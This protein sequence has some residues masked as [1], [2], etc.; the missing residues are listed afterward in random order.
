MR[1]TE[2][3]A[4]PHQGIRVPRPMWEA[5]GRV[6]AKRGA[7]SRNDRIRDM[8]GG[9][10]RRYGDEQDKADLAAALRELKAR[11]SRKGTRS[12][13]QPADN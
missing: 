6:C 9:D 11:R 1:E 12:P 4:T 7:G 8:I 3:N 5:F 13:R 10:I 2:D